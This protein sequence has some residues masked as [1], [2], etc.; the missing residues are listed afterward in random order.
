MHHFLIGVHDG[1]NREQPVRQMG[2]QA[3]GVV[4]GQVFVQLQHHLA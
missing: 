3:L 2:P 4:P 1:S